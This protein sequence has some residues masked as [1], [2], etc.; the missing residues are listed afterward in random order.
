MHLV[1][2]DT[3]EI[4]SYLLSWLYIHIHTHIYIWH[5]TIGMPSPGEGYFSRCQLSLVVP[6]A[7]C[8]TEAFSAF[9][10]YFGMCI[11]VGLSQ[12]MFRQPCW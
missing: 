12:L 11:V 3:G 9:L 2:L 8:R 10:I 6:S 1:L 7:L 5:M 4:R